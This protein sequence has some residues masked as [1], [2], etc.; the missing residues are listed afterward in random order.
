M[1]KYA[2]ISVDLEIRRISQCCV[3]VPTG[4]TASGL[5]IKQSD[6]AMGRHTNMRTTIRHNI[7]I[8]FLIYFTENHIL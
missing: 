5:G 3:V 8:V 1:S 2:V 7:P 4:K 6:A